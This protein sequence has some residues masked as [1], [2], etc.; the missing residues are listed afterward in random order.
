MTCA[1]MPHTPDSLQLQVIAVAL[2]VQFY[3]LH[4]FIYFHLRHL[5]PEFVFF[6]PSSTSHKCAIYFGFQQF[7]MS[8]LSFIMRNGV[9]MTLLVRLEENRIKCT[10]EVY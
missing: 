9:L 10:P 7:R 2:L 6:F 1:C 5:D 4:F 3:D 8:P